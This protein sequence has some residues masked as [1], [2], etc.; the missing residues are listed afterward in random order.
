[1]TRRIPLL[2]TICVMIPTSARASTMLALDLTELARSADVVVVAEVLGLQ[3]EPA[4]GGIVTRVLVR[5]ETQVAGQSSAGDEL[6]LLIP[7]GELDGLGMLVHGSPRLEPG[8][9]YLLFLR[10]HTPEYRI[11]GLAQGALPLQ[12]SGA[13]GGMMVTTPSN[14][15]GLVRLRNGRLQPAQPAIT[16]PTALHD[17]IAT[18]REARHGR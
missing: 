14:L 17:V 7:G 9:R 10:Q 12:P 18:I 13:S 1:M 5:V 3:A 16:A 2:L 8:R 6:E 11:V 15:P 4:R